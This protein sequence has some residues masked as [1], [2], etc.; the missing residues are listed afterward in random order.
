[1]NR[2]LALA[3]ALLACSLL[4]LPHVRTE[5]HVAA[6]AV[7]MGLAG[8]FVIVIFFSFWS[9]AYGRRHLGRIQGAAQALTVVASAVGPLLLA[10][11]VTRTGSYAAMF[12]LLAVVVSALGLWAWFV[13]LPSVRTPTPLT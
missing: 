11:C 6:Y 8:G 7:V 12:Y 10:E 3:M 5:A 4:A 2:L 1:M 13:T 9:L